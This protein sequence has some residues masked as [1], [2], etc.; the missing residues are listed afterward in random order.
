[1]VTSNPGTLSWRMELPLTP[2]SF[3]ISSLLLPSAASSLSKSCRYCSKS[4]IV[5]S[6]STYCK[7]RR[8]REGERSRRCSM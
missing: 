2:V 3:E 4:L 5:P 1:L 8:R 6:F 7:G